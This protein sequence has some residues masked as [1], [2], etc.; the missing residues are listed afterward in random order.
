MLAQAGS[1]NVTTIL[2]NLTRN[3]LCLSPHNTRI[4]DLYQ[5]RQGIFLVRQTPTLKES[6]IANDTVTNTT[7]DGRTLPPLGK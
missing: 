7:P 1:G 6:S 4:N 3:Y 5:Y 2:T